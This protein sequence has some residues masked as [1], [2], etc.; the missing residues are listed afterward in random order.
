LTLALASS[1]PATVS[2]TV[3]PPKPPVKLYI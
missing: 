3:N 1:A 2:G